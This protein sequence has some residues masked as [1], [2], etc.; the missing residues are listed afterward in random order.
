MPSKIEKDFIDNLQNFTDSLE[1][2]VELLKKQHE[3]GGDAVNKMSA[4]MDGERLKTI[5]EEIKVLSETTGRIDSRTKEILS[6]VKQARKAKEGGVFQQTSDKGNTKKVVDGVKLI[7]L[8]AVGVLAIGMAFK[9]IGKVDPL[10]VLALSIAIYTIAIAFEKLSNIKGMTTKKAVAVSGLMVIM[11]MA[12]MLSSQIL[13]WTAPISLITAFSIL[14]VSATL[15]VAVFLLFKAVEHLDLSKPKVLKNMLL[16][17]IILPIIASAIVLSS[18]ILSLTQP[19]TLEQGLTALAIGA[20]LG[21]TAYLLLKG[22]KGQDLSNPKTL[23]NILLLPLI[24][25]MIAASIALSSLLLKLV[26]PISLQQGLSALAIGGILGLTTFL[27]LNGLKGQNLSDSKMLKNILL[28]PLIIPII[29]GAIVI[30]SMILQAFS[31]IKNPTDVLITGSIIALMTAGFGVLAWQISKLGISTTDILKAGL[32]IV[33]VS[34]ALVASSYILASFKPLTM[35]SSTLMGNSLAMGVAILAFLPVVFVISKFNISA[36][37]ILKA[38]LAIVLIATAI[39]ASSWILSLGKY[40]KYPSLEWAGGA[41]L[42]LLA[43]GLAAFAISFIAANPL[44]Y[45]GIAIIP[46]IAAS[47][48]ATS[49]IL[50]AG[51]YTG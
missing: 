27:L 23:K 24:L 41:G 39:T 5:S 36:S 9:I 14:A 30:S 21:I 49:Y 8:I 11:A 45:A 42:S 18:F 51:K 44:F 47:I 4:S 38:G 29:M 25:P 32:T 26:Q 37:S 20:I 3:K 10:S 40:D 1:N 28:L 7:L 15:G 16:L 13:R 43:F 33:L 31:P 6:E 19:I 35:N 17:P 48:V 2:L 22:L 12:I 50:S 34:A 46:L